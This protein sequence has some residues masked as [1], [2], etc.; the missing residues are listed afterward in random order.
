MTRK[1]FEAKA[2]REAERKIE[3]PPGWWGTWRDLHG[4]GG[5]RVRKAGMSWTLRKN[6]RL[7]LKTS[8]AHAIREG[9]KLAKGAPAR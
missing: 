3:A 6:G 7:I 4:P 5:V 2:I 8:R 9:Q 1:Q